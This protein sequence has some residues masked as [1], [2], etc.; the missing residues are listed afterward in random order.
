MLCL[1]VAAGTACGGDDDAATTT[2]LTD[3]QAERLAS[4]LFDN[5]DDGGSSFTMLSEVTTSGIRLA[6]DG[7]IDWKAHVGHAFVQASGS[8]E[9]LTEVYWRDDMV[10]ERRPSLNA[11]V[12]AAGIGDYEFVARAPDIEGRELD[13]A[14]AT[15]TG[16]A[17]PQRDNPLLIAQTDGSAHL[18]DDELGDVPVE[19]L[20][21]GTRS[22]YW[23]ALDDGRLV[24]FEA[25]N[26][27]GTRPVLIEIQ[28][29]GART[30]EGPSP[31]AIV[32][33][34]EIGELYDANVGENATSP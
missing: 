8:D 30:I 29:R 32:D 18:R 34:G 7:E 4:A 23:L 10:L 14:L 27:A 3:Q 5:Y 28:D 31:T 22:V 20:R 21:Y 15:L 26:Q 24:R 12:S 16:L 13:R 11:L 6:L 9:T 33:V 25:N 19:V 2:P 1:V 17:S